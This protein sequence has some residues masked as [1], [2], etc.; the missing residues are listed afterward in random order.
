MRSSADLDMQS[1]ADLDM[2]SECRDAEGVGA[3]IG[4]RG[5]DV[6]ELGTRG[7]DGAELRTRGGD[8]AEL[9]GKI[10]DMTIIHT[11]MKIQSTKL[12]PP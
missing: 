11:L 5:G 4:M 7:G 3:E 1:S 2:R 10:W 12:K 9:C 8:G 6:A